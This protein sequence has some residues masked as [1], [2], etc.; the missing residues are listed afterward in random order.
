MCAVELL[1]ASSVK[2]LPSPSAGAWAALVPDASVS[3]SCISDPV[4]VHPGACVRSLILKRIGIQDHPGPIRSHIGAQSPC[5]G[6]ALLHPS[7]SLGVQAQA[8]CQAT[9]GSDPYCGAVEAVPYCRG[10]VW[11]VCL[12]MQ[13][14]DPAV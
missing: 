3:G 9:F 12:H 7:K 5:P 10:V 2:P 13:P 4:S 11:Y 1:H 8:K 6:E 14:V